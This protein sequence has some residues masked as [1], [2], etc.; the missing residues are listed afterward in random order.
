MTEL[1]IRAID[2]PRPVGS[3]FAKIIGKWVKPNLVMNPRAIVVPDNSKSKPWR[4]AVIAAADSAKLT[5]MWLQ[6]NDQPVEVDMTFWLTRPETVRRLLPFVKPDVDK[7]ARN[8]L[9]GLTA[10][11]VFAD[12]AVVTDL[13]V[14]KRYADEHHRPGARI[15]VRPLSEQLAVL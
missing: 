6:L 8:T 15:R 11:H 13:I 1:L 10:A 7:L 2:E 4:D 9:D 14:R 5:A 3:F 12:D